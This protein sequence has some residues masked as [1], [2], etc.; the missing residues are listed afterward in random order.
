MHEGGGRVGQAEGQHEELEVTVARAERGLRH[1]L[2][3]DANLMVAAAQVD[4]AEVARTLQPIEQLVDARQ[5]VAVLD[6]D[7]VQRAVVDA[8]AHGAILLLHEQDRRTEGRLD[9]AG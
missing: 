3:R 5:R 9:W 7:V 6:G 8:H 1:V 4:L 2:G